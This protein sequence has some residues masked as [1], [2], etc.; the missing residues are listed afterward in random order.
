L[1]VGE[2]VYYFCSLDCAKAFSNN[3]ERFL[4]H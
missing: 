1:R 3:P 2:R 4:N